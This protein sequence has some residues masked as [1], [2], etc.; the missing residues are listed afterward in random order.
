VK[1]Q[2]RKKPPGK[3]TVRAK[4]KAPVPVSPPVNNALQEA[5]ARLKATI[6][7]LPDILFVVDRAGRIYDFHAPN[8]ELL[9]VPPEQFLGRKMVDLLPEPAAGIV[10]RAIRKAAAHGHHA[11]SSYPL[12]TPTGV[13]WFEISVAAQGEPRK[14]GGRLVAIVRDI[15]E[16]RQAEEALR[17]ANDLLEQRVAA[18][19]AELQATL[20][21]IG[22]GFL[23]CDAEWRVVYFNPMA[24]RLLNIRRCRVLGNNLW[25]VFPRLRGTPLE[26]EFR[27]AAAG[28]GRDLEQF[29]SD[30]WFR[31]RCY[32][33]EGG[34][35]SV[36]FH[37]VT[38]WKMVGKEL[39]ESEEKFRILFNAAH[40][41]FFLWDPKRMR[42][43]MANPAVL[44]MLGY[45]PNE[46]EATSFKKMHFKE[47]LP[48]ISQLVSKASRYEVIGLEEVTFRRKD[49]SALLSE[50]TATPVKFAGHDYV[51]VAIRDITRRKRMEAELRQSREELRALLA[52]LERARE[53][54]R[55]RIARDIH[56]DFGQNL[57]AIKMD[58][59][60]IGR[61]AEK[62][63]L[64]QPMMDILERTASGIEIAD[65]SL[66]LV[67]ELATQLRPGVL[68]RLGLG[69]ALQ[70]EARRFQERHG[71]KC[72]AV[73]PEALP[74]L[75]PD[76]VTAL[77]RI[78]QE[79][80]TNVARHARAD[81]IAAELE[82]KGDEACL[83][84]RDNGVGIPEAALTSPASLGLIGMRERTAVLGGCAVFRR[85]KNSGTIVEVRIPRNT[86]NGPVGGAD[87]E[88][89]A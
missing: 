83:R 19:T 23:T 53:E 25:E 49:G 69:P 36:Y 77:F 41:G 78:F 3:T 50:A 56:D 12:P 89:P 55:I 68:D 57:T 17:Q 38:K 11:G 80:L 31:V 2:L 72:R 86:S 88:K 62:S 54:E 14:A 45:T 4:K 7:A 18:R 66:A 22:D 58:L 24:D 20:D 46:F 79:C 43:H 15:T 61:I 21:S 64:S 81:T 76:V 39:R 51:L 59:H 28:E 82:M 16:R 75:H 48:F 63:N 60:Q 1:S 27:S 44:K 47:D 10:H 85:G 30:R 84:V 5:N 74:D 6:D 13:R 37:D 32:P 35:I 71:I 40:D 26:H 8:P 87:E 73:V 52:S 29:Y 34:G 70:Y 65:A 42:Y 67:H 9:Y 33:R